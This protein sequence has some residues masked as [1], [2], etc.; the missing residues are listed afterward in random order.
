ML[1]LTTVPYIVL[2]I[3]FTF[4]SSSHFLIISFYFYSWFMCFLLLHP[5]C[6]LVSFLSRDFRKVFRVHV[7]TRA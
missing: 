2:W 1:I 3:N 6:D 4:F 7:K 5:C